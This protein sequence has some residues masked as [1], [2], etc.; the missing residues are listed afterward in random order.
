MPIREP[1]STTNTSGA[2]LNNPYS[3]QDEQKPRL[4]NASPPP[5]RDAVKLVV[6]ISFNP[7]HRRML[8]ELSELHGYGLAATLR[9]LVVEAFHSAKERRRLGD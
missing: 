4:A 8:E 7:K 6:H 5:K 3:P 9:L 1:S 2:A